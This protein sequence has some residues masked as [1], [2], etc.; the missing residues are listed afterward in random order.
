MP[1]IREHVYQDGKWT[2]VQREVSE[3]EYRALFPRGDFPTPRIRGT[4]VVKDSQGVVKSHF[5]IGN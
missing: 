4:G 3:E 2:E 5:V 1:Q